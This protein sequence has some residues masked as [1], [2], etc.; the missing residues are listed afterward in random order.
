[1][2]WPVLAAGTKGNGPPAIGCVDAILV[3]P[4]RSRA[5]DQALRQKFTESL[6]RWPVG[7]DH[8]LLH[9]ASLK[10]LLYQVSVMRRKQD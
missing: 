7:S 5:A 3:G 2:I 4:R 10:N 8:T 6:G 1:M 9:K